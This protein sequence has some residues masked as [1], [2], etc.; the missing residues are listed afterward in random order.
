MLRLRHPVSLLLISALVVLGV[1][2]SFSAP[3]PVRADAPDVEF[4]ALRSEAIL[5]DL[6]QGVMA[7]V[8]GSSANLVV[9]ERIVSHLESSGYEVEIQSRFHCNPLFGACSPVDNVVAIKPG[10]EGKNAVL[11]TAHYDSSWTGP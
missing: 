6:L 3:E 8:S 11:L 9:R 5:R 1:L 2:R 4:S 7:H 10:S